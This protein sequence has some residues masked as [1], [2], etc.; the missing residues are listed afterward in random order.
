M[1][2]SSIALFFLL[3]AFFI[4][5]DFCQAK[6]RTIS[7]IED[8]EVAEI[9]KDS[10]SSENSNYPVVYLLKDEEYTLD[11]NGI[12]TKKE[13]IL[14][15]ILNES[16]VD[17]GNVSLVYNSYFQDLQIIKARTIRDDGSIAEVSKEAIQD[18]SPY[19]GFPIY[20]DVFI[21]EISFPAVTPGS[22]IEYEAL[23]KD[24]KIVMEKGFFGSF[25][26]PF[27]F[28]TKVSRLKVNVPK[29]TNLKFYTFKIL[30]E[31]PVITEGDDNKTYSW[32]IKNEFPIHSFEVA[33]PPYRQI[34]PYIFFTTIDSWDKVAD[35]FR[36]LTKGQAS[37]DKNIRDKVPELVGKEL[38]KGDNERLIK[39]L[40]YFV[41][42]K[43]RYVGIELKESAFK[44][45]P[46]PEVLSNQYGDCKGK[47]SLLISMLKVLDIPAYYALL[48]T[49][50]EGHTLL[51][52][53]SLDFNHCIVAVPQQDG[54]IFLDPTCEFC[55]MGQLSPLEQGVD[56]F[57]VLDKGYEFK[58]SSV[59]NPEDNMTVSTSEVK[60]QG[61]TKV[62][63]IDKTILTGSES[64]P[65]RYLVKYTQQNPLKDLMSRSL[66]MVFP[67]AKLEKFTFSDA[68][69]LDEPF[70]V[71]AE[72]G[73]KNFASKSGELIIFSISDDS[74]AAFSSL[75]GSEY[76]K[77]PIRF[78]Y[79]YVTKEMI[80]ISL[81]RGYKIKSLPENINL[82]LR[83]AAY[84]KKFISDS[85]ILTIEEQFT[86]KR[87][88]ISAGKFGEFK[89]M[90][91]KINTEAQKSIVLE[92]I[93]D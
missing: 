52:Y 87:N 32:E 8:K 61:E 89:N 34:C 57:I 74:M 50:T 20:S 31:T 33:K 12:S 70:E 47:A 7:D 71:S 16:G 4:K 66:N 36:D 28:L 11:K 77:Y 92:K 46:A 68:D 73:V 27:G 51:D 22:V 17:F 14:I 62:N 91:N 85:G 69:N 40:Y 23:W 48:N 80:K 56:I 26:F 19:V 39:A 38:L 86:L 53:P 88:E 58:K 5:N 37:Y 35:W 9:I 67:G 90:V 41:S 24:K 43:I 84:S 72:F 79:P 78:P 18:K 13:H 30:K 10:S 59:S 93:K 29:N 3:V 1:K 49:R 60:F 2:K 63:I 6:E 25:E 81:P 44:P 64:M 65:F 42:Q 45:Y 54:Y 75:T 83:F 76:R 21:R 15:K 55:R 82:D